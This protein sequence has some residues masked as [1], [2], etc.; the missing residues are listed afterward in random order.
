MVIEIHLLFEFFFF[1]L[2]NIV[3]KIEIMAKFCWNL[4]KVYFGSLS[5]YILKSKPYPLSFGHLYLLFK[6]RRRVHDGMKY[7]IKTISKYPKL[8][9]EIY[10]MFNKF[11]I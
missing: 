5:I 8:T 11:T 4:M 6:G 7:F 10:F 9:Y 1:G 3:H 2:R